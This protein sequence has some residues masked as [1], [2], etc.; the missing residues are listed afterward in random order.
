MK[1]YNFLSFTAVLAMLLCFLPT[2]NL[3]AQE[4]NADIV[5]R[6]KK[7]IKKT[8]KQV[9]KEAKQLEKDGWYCAPGYLMEEMLEKS[10]YKTNEEDEEGYPRWITSQAASVGNS[11]IAAKNQAIEAAK[12]ELAGQ[13]E[14]TIIAIVE[15]SFGN[16]QLNQEEAASLTKTV[17]G[18]K[19]IISK[20]MGR[21]VIIFEAYRDIGRNVEATVTIAYDTRKAL[22]TSVQ[23]IK[24]ELKEDAEDIHKKLDQI[25]DLDNQ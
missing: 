20:K 14:T 15:N 5:K 3:V 19:N 22:E 18:S 24:E 9:K 12:L 11:K 7:D 13:L 4:S 16:E 23:S 10:Y 8:T 21:V 1:L 6:L 25:M 17:T 2:Q